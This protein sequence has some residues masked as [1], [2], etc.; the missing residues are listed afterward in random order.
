[1]T[2]LGEILK[3]VEAIHELLLKMTA[4]DETVSKAIHLV[5]PVSPF[6]VISPFPMTQSTAQM[7]D[8]PTNEQNSEEETTN[9]EPKRSRSIWN[10]SKFLS[11]EDRERVLA[12]MDDNVME[13]INKQPAH[14]RVSF[15]QK[16]LKDNLKVNVSMYLTNKI[17]NLKN[18][19]EEQH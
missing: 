6:P 3:H 1:M 10:S 19:K 12:F 13:Q 9:E 18:N 2:E 7:I 14:K 8:E 17:I 11:K 5:R 4:E 15:T 16:L